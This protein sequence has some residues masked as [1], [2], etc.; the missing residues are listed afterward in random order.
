MKYQ[1]LQ[2]KSVAELEEM[3]KEDKIKLGKF[4][5]E[6]ANKTLK[7]SSQIGKT[8]K[9]IAQIMTAIKINKNK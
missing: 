3:L 6:L 2:N 5:F 1:D 4:R 8:R 9:E 7:D